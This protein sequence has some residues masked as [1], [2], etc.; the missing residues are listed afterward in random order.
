LLLRAAAPQTEKDLNRTDAEKKKGEQ[1]EGKRGIT[2]YHN[3]AL[4]CG[5]TGKQARRLHRGKLNLN[6]R[7][8]SR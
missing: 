6:Q 4:P 8:E 3:T 1:V 5:A 7:A 2:Q